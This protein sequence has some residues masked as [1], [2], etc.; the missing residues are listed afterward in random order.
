MKAHRSTRGFSL[1]ELLLV[2]SILGVISI[3]AVPRF[4]GARE[5]ARQVG[6]ARA[7][8]MA[9]R[10]ALETVRADTGLYPAA[11]AYVWKQ[12]GTLPTI[13]PAVNF[14]IKNASKMDFTL[15]VNADRLSYTIV[16]VDSQNAKQL[17]KI[18][19]NGS[20]VP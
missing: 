1:I 20:N 18:D 6:D 9:L 17:V 12:D 13:T 14:V 16:G 7:N 5:Y 4:L 11:A 2:L 15:T 19:Q 8:A 10:M 3:I